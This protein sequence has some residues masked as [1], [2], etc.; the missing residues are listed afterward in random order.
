[1]VWI[2]VDPYVDSGGSVFG[3]LWIQAMDLCG[4]VVDPGKSVS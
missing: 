1:M 4:S 2:L 3:S